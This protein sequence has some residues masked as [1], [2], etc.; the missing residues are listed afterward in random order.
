MSRGLG[1][2][3]RKVLEIIDELIIVE[4]RVEIVCYN[5]G[6]RR[7]GSLRKIVL[8]G[9]KYYNIPD[10]IIDLREAFSNAGGISFREWYGK[11]SCHRTFNRAIHSLIKKG[12]LTPV[13]KLYIINSNYENINHKKSKECFLNKYLLGRERLRFLKKNS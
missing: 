3:E 12:Y 1:K 10:F 4:K 13:T 9:E 8:D 6:D 7:C 5:G 2:I 11:I